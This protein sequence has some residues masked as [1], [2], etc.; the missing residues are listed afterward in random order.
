MAGLSSLR[1]LL[2]IVEASMLDNSTHLPKSQERASS[3]ELTE[4]S[5]TSLFANLTREQLAAMRLKLCLAALSEIDALIDRS[6]RT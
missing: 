2:Q 3:F 4:S 5:V 6:T 1:N